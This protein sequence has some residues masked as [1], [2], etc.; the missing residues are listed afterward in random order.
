[1]LTSYERSPVMSTYLVAMI[2]GDYT[3]VP[4]ND[5]RQFILVRGENTENAGPAALYAPAILPEL[6]RRLMTPF[7]LPKLDHAAVVDMGGAM[8]NWGLIIYEYVTLQQIYTCSSI[9]I[10]VL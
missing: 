7:P 3:R 1:M 9:F 10:L 8:E 4:T 2:V 5:A 6:E